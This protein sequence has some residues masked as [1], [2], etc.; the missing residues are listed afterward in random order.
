MA[1]I[2][3]QL[4]VFGRYPTVGRVKTR[5]ISTLGPAGAASLQKRLTEKT[6]AVAQTT[7]S[8]KNGQLVFCHDGGDPKQ[9]GRWLGSANIHCLPQI[10]GNLGQRMRAAFQQAFDKG[11]ERVL[12][13]GTDIP[14]M[15]HEV[16]EK[17][18]GALT[19]H[20]LVLGP[21]TD[22]GYW[23]VG[24]NAF[25]DIFSGMVWSQPDVL[26]KT[27]S[28]ARKKG[29][30][31]FLAERLTDLDTAEDL[32]REMG[33]QKRAPSYLSVIIPTLNEER[34][35]KETIDA[36]RSPDVELIISDGGSTDRTLAI[37][38]ASG[39]RIVAGKKGRALQ[40]NQG[41]AVARGDVLLFLH[42]DTKL[43][44]QYVEHIFQSLMDRQ[45]VLGAFQFDTDLK[46]PAMKRVAYWA[47]LRAA[48]LRLPYGDQGLFL[49]REDFFSAGGFPDVP[50]AEDLH[51]AREMARRGRVV[52][53]P[54]AA[55]TSARRWKQLGPLRTT[56]VNTLIAVGCLAGVSPHLLAPLYRWPKKRLLS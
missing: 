55:V 27:L 21:S 31:P 45:I 10:S 23:L 25:Q 34:G 30:T 18:L 8:R 33:N 20:D 48:K 35:I 1:K 11:A 3:F 15:T 12:L 19:A 5:L 36:A 53:A 38:S 46:T 2:H 40:Q 7:T 4:I 24:M 16:L 44:E 43:P 37:A 22:G 56:L 49:R 9:I 13:V 14:G 29:L 41:A 26:E 42:A 6:I 54:A 47:N 50:I 17:A 51:L 52:I 39:G 32:E 28:R